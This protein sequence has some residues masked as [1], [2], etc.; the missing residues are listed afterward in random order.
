VGDAE[1]DEVISST[2]IR[3]LLAEGDVVEAARVLGRHHEVRGTVGRGDSRARAWGTPTANVAV[4]QEMQLPADGIYAGWY[5]RPD[6]SV[7]PAAIS[8]G[9]RPTF[10]PDAE[11][12]LLEAYLRDFSGELYGERARVRFVARLREE[13]KFETEQALVEQ[14]HRDVEE[15][16]AALGG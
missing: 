13:R 16:R 8:L 11:S 14:I 15:V 1:H 5:Q 3:R 9:R 4:P 12:S 10:Y 6:G 2:R 7:H